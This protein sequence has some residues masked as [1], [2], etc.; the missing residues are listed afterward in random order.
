MSEKELQN[1]AKGKYTLRL[2]ALRLKAASMPVEDFHV[3]LNPSEVESVSEEK[4]ARLASVCEF[5][6]NGLVLVPLLVTWLSLA[7]AALAYTQ[8]YSRSSDSFF[9]QW[10]DGF[11]GTHVGFPI[12]SFIETAKIDVILISLL[13]LLTLL[14][15]IFESTAHWRASKLRS[16][17]DDELFK[18]ASSSL[19]ISLGEGPENKQP[20]WAVEVHTAINHLNH[21]LEGVVALV[22][23]S[24]AT[25][26]NMADTSETTLKNIM[27]TSQAK[28]E[29]SVRE[30]QRAINNQQVGV[31]TLINSSQKVLNE[32]VDTSQTTLKHLI[33]TSQDKLE[34]SVREFRVA[35]SDQREAVDKFM[36]GINEIRRVLDGLEKIYVE[37]EQ[38]YLSLDETLP[39][40]EKTFETM[41]THQHT[42]V[43]ALDSISQQTNLA[44][45]A[46]GSIATQFTQTHLVQSTSQAATQMKETA[47][48]M[49]KIAAQ[50]NDTVNHMY[51]NLVRLAS[52]TP[53]KT[54]PPKSGNISRFKSWLE[55]FL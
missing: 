36:S 2:A 6:R 47:E 1:I 49:G 32:L 37:G 51:K 14:V 24:Q 52:Q 22:N 7:I 39:R 19:V 53:V 13:F 4:Y 46:I 42:T 9:K 16:W 44:S 11:P 40:I 55:K 15:Q 43:T 3:F 20:A 29:S 45:Q 35:I 12:I 38:I 10:A 50:M 27:E 5:G 26:K 48:L 23:S 41:A 18:L 21:T 34:G 33:D 28:L 31:E 17:L 30:F 54:A 25:L 8:T